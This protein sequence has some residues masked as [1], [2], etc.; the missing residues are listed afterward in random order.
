[1]KP[2]VVLVNTARGGIVDEQALAD[3]LSSGQVYAAG[4]DVFE[5]EPVAR[6]NP[7][8]EHSNVVV[9]PHIS[10]ATMITRARMAD[11]AADNALAALKGQPM[12]HCVNP[13]V[14]G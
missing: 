7:L 1:M 2:G 4:I 8:L 5:Q 6:D 3:A 13:E 9:A 12:P 11:I 14:Y 10:S